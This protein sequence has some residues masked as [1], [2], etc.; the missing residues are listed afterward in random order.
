MNNSLSPLKRNAENL[1]EAAQVFFV[2]PIIS[3][4]QIHHIEL[5]AVDL[6]CHVRFERRVLIVYGN[7]NT[8]FVGISF[9]IVVSVHTRHINF[10]NRLDVLRYFDQNSLH[11]FLCLSIGS[12]VNFVSATWVRP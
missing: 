8:F 10:I 2:Y 11:V 5:L 12:V 3:I 7:D 9:K 4:V 1:S 6:L